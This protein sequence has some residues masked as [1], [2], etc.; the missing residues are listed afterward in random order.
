[1]FTFTNILD[2]KKKTDIRKVG[3]TKSKRKEIKA[4]TMPWAL[5]PNRKGDSKIN[6]QISLFI[7][8]L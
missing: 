2:V 4:V 1:M 8:G 6:Y 3:S 5:K 7:I